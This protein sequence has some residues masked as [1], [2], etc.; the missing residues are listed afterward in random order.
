MTSL[1]QEEKLRRKSREVF[2]V[3]YEDALRVARSKSSSEA[4]SVYSR[5]EGEGQVYSTPPTSQRPT[6]NV[7]S[8]IASPRPT[9]FDAALHPSNMASSPS[10]KPSSLVNTRRLTTSPPKSRKVSFAMHGLPKIGDDEG[11]GRPGIVTRTVSWGEG[12][13]HPTPPRQQPR[14]SLS[15]EPGLLEQERESR[16]RFG[17]VDEREEDEQDIGEGK[18][19]MDRMTEAEGG[20][21]GGE[22]DDVVN[23]V[24]LSLREDNEMLRLEMA[25]L[26]EEFRM[27]KEAVLSAE[28]SRQ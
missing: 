23:K 16:A 28:R 9:P 27:L 6:S 8:S 17:Q 24:R 26:K 21:V 1:E 18:A 13:P 14:R 10:K 19:E 7:Q 4:S 22:R 15:F 2:E 5:S 11:P 3:F 20:A 12:R 25:M